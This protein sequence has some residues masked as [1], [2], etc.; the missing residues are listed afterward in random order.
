[1]WQQH[2]INGSDIVGSS[3]AIDS[4]F[5]II[6]GNKITN[7]IGTAA[8]NNIWNAAAPGA[9]HRLIDGHESSD[10]KQLC[11]VLLYAAVHLRSST[12]RCETHKRHVKYVNQSWENSNRW[13][14]LAVNLSTSS[15]IG[16]LTT[17]RMLTLYSQAF[18]Q[19]RSSAASPSRGEGFLSLSE[20][21]GA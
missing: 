15:P 11:N 2:D 1:M 10:S 18:K 16:P 12:E 6:A 20:M 4:N 9:K 13:V 5:D 8:I 19:L 3:G 21:V 17:S 7:A 14:R